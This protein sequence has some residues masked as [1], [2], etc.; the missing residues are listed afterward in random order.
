MNALGY[1]SG[2]KKTT[3]EISEILMGSHT[4]FPLQAGMQ[5]D[6]LEQLLPTLILLALILHPASWLSSVPQGTQVAPFQRDN[7]TAQ[8]W[9]PPAWR[10]AQH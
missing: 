4:C 1:T 8:K 5:G 10:L 6:H 7:K 9:A 2:C 3:L